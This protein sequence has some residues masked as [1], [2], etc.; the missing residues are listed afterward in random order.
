MES[1]GYMRFSKR[2]DWNTLETTLA[3]AHRERKTAGLPIVDLT[4]SNPTQCGFDYPADLLQPLTNPAAFDYDPD[5][6]GSVQ[7]R[8]AVCRY[9][10]NHGVT[11]SPEQVLLTTSTSEA[12]GYLFKL[13]CDPGSEVLIPLPSYPLFDFLAQAEAVELA[14]APFFYD[15]GW[16]LD[17]DGLR[18]RISLDTRAIVLVHPNNPTGHFIKASEAH[19]LAGV[20]RENKLALIVDEV[21]LDYGDE[22]GANSSSDRMSFAARDLDIPVF[23][24]SGISKICGLPQMKVAWLIALGPGSKEALARLEVLGDTYLSMNAPMQHALPFWLQSRSWIQRQIQDRVRVNLA[25]LDRALAGQVGRENFINRLKFEGGWYTILRIPAIQ[26]DEMTTRELL[27]SGVW[28]HPGYFFGMGESGWL[29][30][31]LLERP[32]DFSRGI[33]IVLEYFEV[34]LAL[35]SREAYP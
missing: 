6:K 25:E 12:Y 16:Q 7:A 5:P 3:Q 11:V 4:V 31:S 2:T 14:Y 9:Y 22:A 28:V 34:K 21:F 20:C 27:D 32:T 30:L 35:R 33:S 17:L 23:V 24:V 1:V 13:L 29:V 26:P 19:D 8:Q 18:Q 15:Y 10:S